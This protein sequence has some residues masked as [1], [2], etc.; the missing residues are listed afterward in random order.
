MP[1]ERAHRHEQRQRIRQRARIARQGL[2]AEDRALLSQAAAE[3]LIA[4]LAAPF[5]QV[6]LGYSA[7]AEE[8][9]PVLALDALRDT[10]AL[11]AYP[12]ITGPGNLSLHACAARELVPGH[13]GIMQPPEDAPVVH[14]DHVE[15]V[16]V[17][18]VAFDTQG[19]RLGYGGGYYD[20]ILVRMPNARRIGVCF[21]GQITNSIPDE[22]HDIH[23]HAIIT[24]TRSFRA[25]SA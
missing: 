22:L 5:P 8:L 16:I 4:S 23:M 13:H 19:N 17:P 10:G 6:V 20:R 3:R 15:L 1:D 7:T 21:D 11:I 14:L 2:A 18:G 24:P 12:R 25:L 9:D